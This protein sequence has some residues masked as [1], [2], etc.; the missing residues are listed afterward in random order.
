VCR[1]VFDVL[2]MLIGYGHD[3]ETTA[4]RLDPPDDFFR[5]RM[6]RKGG[7]QRGRGGA[8]DHPSVKGGSRK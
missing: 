5:L 6:V 2:Y 8:Q 7:G 4:L 1:A 3:S